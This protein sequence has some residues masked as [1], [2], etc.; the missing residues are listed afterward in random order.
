MSPVQQPQLLQDLLSFHLQIFASH[1]RHVL[2][3]RTATGSGLAESGT[4]ESAKLPQGNT[5]SYRLTSGIRSD[6]LPQKGSE[7]P[8]ATHLF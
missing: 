4:Q 8:L 5:S 7:E 3:T 1:L 6:E 2:S